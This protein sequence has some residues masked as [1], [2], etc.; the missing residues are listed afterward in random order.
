MVNLCTFLLNAYGQYE[1]CFRRIYGSTRINI[2]QVSL[3]IIP[4]QTSL[5]SAQLIYHFVVNLYSLG[6]CGILVQFP[7]WTIDFTLLKAS[8]RVLGTSGY[9]RPLQHLNA[10]GS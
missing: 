2:L 3:H 9:P 1:V 7:A 6:K 10:A 4:F 5:Q 8:S